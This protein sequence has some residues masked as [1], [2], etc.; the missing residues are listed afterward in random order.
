[1][2]PPS[3]MPS[4]TS[5]LRL[6]RSGSALAEATLN[7]LPVEVQSA[8]IAQAP[9]DA[10]TEL[11]ML[12]HA[13]QELVQ[14]MTP[15]AIAQT[16]TSADD[17]AVLLARYATP[18][19]LAA[20][21][22]IDCRRQ[23]RVQPRRF[24]RWIALLVHASE[25]DLA[26]AL[27]LLD[28]RLL[29]VGLQSFVR[30]APGLEERTRIER[31]AGGAPWISGEDLD[32]DD[33]EVATFLRLLE[34]AAPMALSELG[35]LLVEEDAEELFSG[36]YAGHEERMEAIGL[37]DY[38]Q[39]AEVYGAAQPRS[40]P[41]TGADADADASDAGAAANARAL[42]PSASEEEFLRQALTALI[43]HRDSDEATIERL[44]QE[45]RDLA[46]DIAIAD[47]AGADQAQSLA[48]RGKAERLVAIGL[49]RLGAGSSARAAELLMTLRLREI[50]RAGIG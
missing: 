21:I 4:V 27:P 25:R 7:A 8:L 18:A 33:E 38:A 26:D 5:L 43:A 41:A 31:F 20:A 30:L 42:A 36:D 37:R 10:R 44:G 9:A 24:R 2:H 34:E 19:Q 39:A 23:G 15:V 50:F 17:D 29:A 32:S 6:V 45:L 16:V 22:D 46:N 3:S 35:A 14:A 47:G 13:C 40:A 49:R 28:P 12:S 11:L 1:M 48:A